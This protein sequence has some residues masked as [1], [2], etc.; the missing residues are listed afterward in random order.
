MPIRIHDP[1]RPSRHGNSSVDKPASILIDG[2]ALY[3]ASRSLYEGLQL[4]YRVLIDVLCREGS[5]PA[6]D[7]GS[8]RWV[9][10]TS[11]SSQNAGQTRFL[12]FAENDLNWVVRRFAPADSY[13]LEPATVMGLAPDS[14]AATRL[15]RFDASIAFAMGRLA[16][17]CRLAVVSDSF[18]ISDALLRT[19]EIVDD[20][21]PPVLAFFGRALDSRWQGVIRRDP[22]APRFIDLDDFADELFGSERVADARRQPKGDFVF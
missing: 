3:L 6:P 12:D 14:R 8:A 10:W 21:E 4:D 22:R 7:A 19:A 5:L 15:V 11:A 2:S 18:A 1:V 16:D 9:M 13:M 20:N 17:R